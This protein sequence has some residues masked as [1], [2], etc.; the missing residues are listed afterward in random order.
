MNIPR[1]HRSSILSAVVLLLWCS[2]SRAQHAD[3]KFDHISLEQGLSN[4]TVTV[5]TQDRQGFLWFGTEDGLNRYD[6]HTFTVYRHD[7]ADSTSLSASVIRAVFVDRRGTVWVATSGG[8]VCSYDPVHDSFIRYEKSWSEAGVFFED[9]TT[10]HLWVGTNAGLFRRDEERNKFVPMGEQSGLLDSANVARVEIDPQGVW[11]VGTMA[12]GLLR[13]DPR[14]AKIHRYISQTDDPYSLSDNRIIALRVDRT[15]DVW[16]GSLR[17]LSRYERARDRFIRY[18]STPSH[19]A[20]PP[21]DD[22]IFDIMEDH[23]GNLWV[24]TFHLSLLRYD[25]PADRFIQYAHDPDDPR[26][27]NDDRVNCMFEDRSGVLWVATYRGGLNRHAPGTEAFIR[28]RTGTNRSPGISGRTVYAM[29]EDRLGNLWFGTF[30]GGI[31]RYDPATHRYSYFDQSAG[32]AGR[33]VLAILADRDGDIWVGIGSVLHRFDHATG[34]FKQIPLIR[35]NT[36]ADGEIKCIIQDGEGDIWIG[37]NGAGVFR[38]D[39]RTGQIVPYRH[40]ADDPNSSPLDAIWSLMQDRRGNIWFASFGNG[41]SS[42]NPS[43][44]AFSHFVHRQGDP[45]SLSNGAVYVVAEGKDGEIWAGTFGGGINRLDPHTGAF[46]HY[47]E[48]QGLPNNF[49]KGILPD[50][51]G[52]VWMSTDRGL[53]CFVPGVEKFIN[54][55]D[56]DGLHGNVFL[57]GAF[58]RTRQGMFLFG[59]DGGV[60]AFF[61]DSIRKSAIP[62]SVVITGIKVFETP[63]QLAQPLYETTSVTLAHDQN[64]LSFDFVALDFAAPE[65]NQYAYMLE[66]ID[67]TWNYPGTRRYA[68]YTHLQP[69][70]YLFKV[71]GANKDGIWN[72]EGASIEITISPPFW[73]QWWFILL[74]LAALVTLLVLGY[75]YRVNKLLEVE[76]L[77]VRI[78]SDLHDDIGSSLTRISLQSELI[79]EGIEPGEVNGYLKNIASMSRELVTTMSDIVWSIDARNDT[80]G[81]LLDKMRDF[82]TNTLSAQG[83]VVSFAH[84]GLDV[85]KKIPVDIRENLYLICKE[86]V[87]NISKHSQATSVSIVL[88]NDFDKF[89]MVITDNGK[90]WAGTGRPTGHGVKNIRMRGERLGGKV[91]FIN[92]Q[93]VRVVLT[94]RRI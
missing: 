89:T 72:E 43:T 81:N 44:G 60:T 16:V 40:R 54:F 88:R 80:M 69:G 13:Y 50:E 79:Q 56:E 19:R 11:W 45:S 10:H 51:R 8:G 90:G 71:K 5:I 73:R 53:S 74:A 86:A 20:P 67:K 78:A 84:S 82:T 28:Y 6:G 31:T 14:T 77:R 62:P 75:N 76:R 85:K 29:S 91:D 25:R 1:L 41:I 18:T 39:K 59:G 63:L 33:E 15:G 17:G 48:K 21:A 2:P 36:R 23:R 93:G 83:I 70:R 55:T 47:K 68:N 27:I 87:N 9:S 30:D 42:F 4:F 38:L 37:T 94:T 12:N 3:L 92:D 52:N 35:P 58:A 61:P 66:G 49:V 7:D 46:T 24:G 57:S 65:R 34:R 32:L 64:V 26:S 22:I